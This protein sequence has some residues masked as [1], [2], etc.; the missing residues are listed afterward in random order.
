MV[1][2]EYGFMEYI[3]L[4]IETTGLDLQHSSII[5]V[6]A[7]LV[8]DN[9]VKD[10][11]SSFVKYMGDLPEIV[12][13][14]TGI[15]EDQ[16][17]S[18]P[19]VQSVMVE[20]KRFIQKRPVVS[21]NG[22]SFDFPILERDGLKIEEKYDSLEFAFFVL[23]TNAHG[24]SVPV[25]AQQFG[26]GSVSHRAL[27]DC[28]MEFEMIRRLQV[29]YETKPKK[30]REAL[31]K[32]TQSVQWWWSNFLPGNA[33]SVDH[34]FDLVADYE[35][36]RKEQESQEVLALETEA[37]DSA[38]VEKY[39][40]PSNLTSQK[41]EMDYSEDRPEQ[42]KMA[43]SITK[44]FNE[45]KHAV[46]EAGTGTGKSKAY[47][48]PSLLFALKNSVPIIIS[49]HTKALQDQLFFKEISHIRD[50]INPDLRVA[51]LKGKRNYV[52]LEKFE[53]F[54]DEVITGSVQRSLYE[55]REEGTRYSIRLAGV[56]LASWILATERGDWDE[57]PYWLKGRIPKKI[58]QEVCNIDEL[59]GNVTC[60]LYE[61]KKCFLVKARLRAKDADL[62][63]VNHA[64]TLSG[65]IVE[66]TQDELSE[67]E[68]PK[69]LYSHTVFPN[70]AK[71]IIFDEAH[72]LEDDATSAWEHVISDGLFQLLFQQ[73]YG[74]RGV[75]SVISSIANDK[76]IKTLHSYVD[77]F[78]T[79]EADLRL[80]INTI[81][82][83]ILPKLV[84]ENDSNPNMYVVVDE[85]PNLSGRKD[86]IDSLGNLRDRLKM[87]LK[88]LSIFSEEA[89]SIRR[90]QR[91]L[92]VR[93]QSIQ[94][95]IKSLDA[96]LGDGNIYVRYIERSGSDI[97]IKAAYLSVAKY[98]KEYVYDNFASV[99]LTS[100]TLTVDKRFNFFANRCGTI[101]IS[102]EKI[103]YYLFRSSFNYEKQVKFFVPKG[104]AYAGNSETHFQKSVEFLE[105]AIIAS[106]G[107]AL[108]L[109]SSH[110]QVAK[111]YAQLIDPLSKNNI[112]LLRQTK[113]MSVNS[114]VRDFKN[115][116]DSVLIGTK[117]LW[118]GIDVPGESLRSLF[119]YK[120]PYPMPGFPLIKFRKQEIDDRGGNSFAE[121][122]EPLAALVL[123]QGFG[124][125]IR[126]STDTGVAVLLDEDLLKKP[127]LLGSLPEGVRP[128][129]AESEEIYKAFNK[130]KN[131][132]KSEN[133][134]I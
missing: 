22:F 123:K 128:I 84:P 86:L 1:K 10:T 107:G 71:F 130:L 49:T 116:V 64:I 111:L 133:I 11:Y 13:R 81:F 121:Y 79:N 72:H 80:D 93:I 89:N 129:R 70:E 134:T 40:T 47:L 115:D 6:G 62:V 55:F 65:I 8:E 26:L 14:I 98:L 110:D 92:L 127:R 21:H 48:V 12:K 78:V 113:N 83:N 114:V 103:N 23:P 52:C 131:I 25:L 73:L 30:Q 120:I 3:I 15:T 36:Y 59:C 35:P 87:I 125:L 95:V 75:I 68:E 31:K 50:T 90:S 61:A 57:L 104:I 32:L 77:S 58:E 42:R 5:E 27:D 91:T 60:E 88:T 109:C 85:I 63:V 100:A 106:N 34:L 4:D 76:G 82:Q 51:V 45:R 117:T 24:H 94:R 96:V 2:S 126:K 112:L 53:E 28:R 102:K 69:K 46:I 124:R 132:F 29:E 119:I 43:L 67:N 122:Y 41:G 19:D 38:E 9:T 66:E 39:F 33:I 56:L 74:K 97:Q 16:L 7:V 101:L 105:K 18:A 20:L 44:V 108:I 54:L 118:E 99:V 17:E 37:I